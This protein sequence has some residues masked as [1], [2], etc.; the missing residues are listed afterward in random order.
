M[1]GP[2]N[3]SVRYVFDEQT[4]LHPKLWQFAYVSGTTTIVCESGKGDDAAAPLPDP[5]LQTQD[6]SPLSI[7]SKAGHLQVAS[8]KNTALI[9]ELYV[10]HQ[11][12]PGLHH[13]KLIVSSGDEEI[14]IKVNLQ[15]WDFIL[16]NKL[17]FVPEMNAY[18]T[19]S[20]NRGYLYY[21]MAHEH[22]TCINRLSYNWG[23]QPSFAPLWHNNNFSWQRWDKAVAPLLDGSAF[24]NLPRANEP[25]DIFYLPINENWPIP[26][27][28]H[29]TP[30][31]WVE[32]ALD[33]DYQKQLQRAMRLF[34]DHL[35]KSDWHDTKF[36]FYLNNKISYRLKD[37]QSSAPWFF[38]E[39]VNTQDFWALRWFG[40]L[41][42]GAKS[43]TLHPENFPFRAD[44]S[45]SQFSRDLLMG[46]V[47]IEY[48]G[49][50][51]LQKTRM[52]HDIQAHSPQSQFAEYGTAN[53]ISA[54]NTQPVLWCITAW[55]KGANGV[56]PWQSIGSKQAWNTAEQTALF[57][58]TPTGPAPSVRLKAF[59]RGQQDVEYLTIFSQLANMTRF[60]VAN[61]LNNFID[62]KDEF[63]QK[64]TTDA[65]TT[66]FKSVSPAN[67]W[68]IR[69]LIGSW[70]SEHHPAYRRSLL[71]KTGTKD[72]PTPR[73]QM[74]FFCRSKPYQVT[75]ARW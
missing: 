50:N 45:Y 22:R 21:Q 57:Y 8:Q 12:T 13:G 29:Y 69:Y 26:I 64:N 41:W 65:G 62:L 58:P 31:Y 42:R 18:G 25:L 39:P 17:S 56:L 27:A 32:E 54:A 73:K 70:I 49:G 36:Q 74:D 15:V 19:V 24:A 71:G 60:E 38:D 46:V 61:W 1:G 20:P 7:P 34:I 11:T 30:S 37:R 35:E 23:G 68:K 67:L 55:L 75:K 9:C 66:E 63:Q 33:G 14:V 47:D 59:T 5:L 4:I 2:Q 6:S 72:K 53:Q 48:L 52:M 10:P 28:K 44:V 3:F 40:Q 51:N 16:P 43:A